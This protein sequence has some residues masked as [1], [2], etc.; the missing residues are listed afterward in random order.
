MITKRDF[1]LHGSC[2]CEKYKSSM[3]YSKTKTSEKS[4]ATSALLDTLTLKRISHEL[5]LSP[6]SSLSAAAPSTTP[7]TPRPEGQ[8]LGKQDT[9][10]VAAAAPDLGRYNIPRV[11]PNVRTPAFPTSSGYKSTCDSCK[12]WNNVLLCLVW[13]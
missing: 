5:L 7:K 2:F 10:A 12:L 1:I 13:M 8:S 6:L 11:L 9:S 4:S 3:L